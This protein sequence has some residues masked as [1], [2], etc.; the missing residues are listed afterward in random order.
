MKTREATILYTTGCEMVLRTLEAFIGLFIE[1]NIVAII[2]QR[3]L[4]K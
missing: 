2:T 4:G 3:I 1:V